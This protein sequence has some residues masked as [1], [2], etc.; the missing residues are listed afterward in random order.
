[1]LKRPHANTE[2]TENQIERIVKLQVDALDHRFLSSDMTQS[3]YDALMR[4][5]NANAD[6]ALARIS[7]ATA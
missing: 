4:A 3:E 5:I 7:R 1:M 6:K 2:M